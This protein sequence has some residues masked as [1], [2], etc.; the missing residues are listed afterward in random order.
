MTFRKLLHLLS[1]TFL[2]APLYS[3][4]AMSWEDL[5]NEQVPELTQDL[6]DSVDLSEETRFALRTTRYFHQKHAARRELESSL[7][8]YN[9]LSHY[10]RLMNRENASDSEY[11]QFLDYKGKVLEFASPLKRLQFS[12]DLESFF[13]KKAVFSLWVVR[14]EDQ[15]YDITSNMKRIKT[16]DGM[17]P[18]NYLISQGKL[19]SKI[20][21]SRNHELNEI[22]YQYKIDEALESIWVKNHDPDTITAKL[23]IEYDD[24]QTPF[25][26]KHGHFVDSCSSP[27]KPL[28]LC[29][30]Q[31]AF[32]NKAYEHS[33]NLQKKHNYQLRAKSFSELAYDLNRSSLPTAIISVKE[34]SSALITKDLGK[35]DIVQ[36]L[37]ELNYETGRMILDLRGCDSEC[38]H[39]RMRD[40]FVCQILAQALTGKNFNSY[41]SQSFSVNSQSL[42]WANRALVGRKILLEQQDINPNLK[43]RLEEDVSS[44][45]QLIQQK[46]S[47]NAIF[48]CPFIDFLPLFDVSHLYHKPV[49]VLVDHTTAGHGELLVSLLQSEGAMVIGEKTRGEPTMFLLSNQ[50]ISEATYSFIKSPFA[51][52]YA[53][54]SATEKTPLSYQGVRP[55]LELKRTVSNQLFPVI[56]IF[57]VLEILSQKASN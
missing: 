8:G 36:E 33:Q 40:T 42:F 26:V 39:S 14:I 4:T 30:L 21:V 50:N 44:L 28:T 25:S 5:E 35:A 48:N 41:F 53:Q 31:K 55:N 51:A 43:Q 34:F 23:E 10:K 46:P 3:C 38:L 12:C 32:R 6:S 29:V 15:F 16:I 18:V 57:E 56:S 1:I 19:P 37:N 11:E 7:F 24:S 27:S 17:S 20:E 9:Y 13:V 2:L 45:N 22:N 47:A 49:T 52:V 54:N